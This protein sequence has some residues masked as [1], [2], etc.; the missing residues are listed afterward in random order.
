MPSF[1]LISGE[2]ALMRAHNDVTDAFR[3]TTTLMQQELERSVLT[4]QMFGPSS[5]AHFRSDTDT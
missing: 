4:S 1:L 2:D 5:G 3:R